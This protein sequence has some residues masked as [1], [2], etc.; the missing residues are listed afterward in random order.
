MIQDVITGSG[1]FQVTVQLLN[2]TAPLPHNY[3]L[4][5]QEVVVVEVSVN[6]S[7]EHIKVIV[8][9]CWVTPTSNP[10]DSYRY[11]FLENRSASSYHL[12][13]TT[14]LYITVS[15]VFYLLLL[16]HLPFNMNLT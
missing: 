15:T 10:A 1:S 13:S 14:L 3:S 9:K 16:V 7:S 12:H 8:N 11:T 5:P 2:G 6:T 4:S